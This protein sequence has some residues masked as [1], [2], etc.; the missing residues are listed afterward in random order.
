VPI[1]EVVVG[2]KVAEVVIDRVVDESDLDFT[3]C[4]WFLKAQQICEVVID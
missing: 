2:F 4:A 1:N 3:A